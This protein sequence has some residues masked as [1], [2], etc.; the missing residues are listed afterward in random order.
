MNRRTRR[1]VYAVAV[2]AAIGLGAPWWGPPLLSRIEAF[3]VRSVSVAGTRF[4]SEFDVLRRAAIPDSASVWND[5][6][7]WEVR[8]EAD[9]LVADAEVVRS[10]A[11]GLEVRIR[12]VEPVA[13]VPTPELVPVDREGRLLPL[14]PARAG[15]DLPILHL[16]AAGAGE[17]IEG[18][19]ARRLL[20]LLT[21]LR[22]AEPGFVARASEL[23]LLEG[24]GA[25]V[26][27]TEGPEGCERVRLP[28]DEPVRALE[29]IGLVLSVRDSATVA[30]DARFDGQ[31]VV[32]TGGAS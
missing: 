4:V 28:L 8:V 20:E 27:L 31:V 22:E 21:R 10:G 26:F 7:N 18:S 2:A 5:P 11:S 3:R 1:R 30:V 12:E 24:G 16:E 14:D 13:L 6:T 15:L 25:E 9:P 32:T 17:R 29:R 23:R 19:E